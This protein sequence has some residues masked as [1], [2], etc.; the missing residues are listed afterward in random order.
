M[1]S[2]RPA[3][4]DDLPALTALAN[5]AVEETTAEW[6]EVPHTVE[7]RRAWL[8]EKRR[9]GH[10]VL[11]A[12]VGGEVVGWAAFG[13]FRDTDRWPGYRST[14][15]HTIHV[16]E[17]AWGRGV[18]RALMGALATA[19]REAGK[20]TLVGGI[21]GANQRSLAF[22]QRLGFREV[23]RLPGIG[24]KWGRRLDLVLVQRDL[25]GPG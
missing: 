21:D 14:V 3:R 13:D 4:E 25:D 11:V 5:V 24:E 6:T 12:E 9:R 7:D 22:H 8:A 18:G 23:G 1:V 16:A 2:V 17:A 20:R 15:E 19:A 10:A